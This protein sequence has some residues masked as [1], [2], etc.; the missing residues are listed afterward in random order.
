MFLFFQILL[1]KVERIR[2]NDSQP[3][4]IPITCYFIKLISS[5]Q[6]VVFLR[7]FMTVPTYR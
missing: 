6:L 4:N 3:L 5:N 7:L 2:Q 1:D